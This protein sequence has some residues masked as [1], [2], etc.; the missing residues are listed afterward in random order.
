MATRE[1]RNLRV[2][3]YILVNKLCTGLQAKVYK[4]QALQTHGGDVCGEGVAVKMFRGQDSRSSLQRELRFLTM[5]QGHRNVVRLVESINHT[6]KLNVLVLELCHKD[7]CTLTSE[8][9]FSEADA[10]DILPGVLSALRHIHQLQIVHR[11][12]KPENIAVSGDGSARVM[13][14]GI[15]ASMFDEVEMRRKCGS[16]GYMAPEIIDQKSYGPPV[17]IFAFGATMYFML[18]HQHPF[19]TAL[20]T[21]ESIMAKTKFCVISFGINF[22][23]V[24]DDSRKLISWCMHEDDKWRPDASF[25]L[26]C[27]PFA[28]DVIGEDDRRPMSFEEQLAARIDMEVRPP[29]DALPK[30]KPERPT[31][32]VT[33]ES[34][35]SAGFVKQRDPCSEVEVSEGLVDEAQPSSSSSSCKVREPRTSEHVSINFGEA[36]GKS[37]ATT[38]LEQCGRKLSVHNLLKA[39]HSML[40]RDTLEGLP[41]LG[42][43]ARASRDVLPELE[44]EV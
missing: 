24:G 27:P 22:D 40:T 11:D 25:A 37:K 39:S 29:T 32:F 16:P 35:A 21:L 43:F 14:F 15:S 17:D 2:P 3:G 18:S 12:I 13:D 8:R 1:Q 6:P 28:A 38:N 34:V 33:R 30:Q 4:A 23:H 19:E 9:V 26:T 5:V 20:G 44:P 10:A 31:P 36:I 41:F 7:L 42:E